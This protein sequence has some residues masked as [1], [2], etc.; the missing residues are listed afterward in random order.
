MNENKIRK[1]VNM[2]VSLFMVCVMCWVISF[3][4][5]SISHSS[6]ISYEYL[7]FDY[8]LRIPSD[9]ILIEGIDKITTRR[10]K[11]KTVV[12]YYKH[13]GSSGSVSTSDLLIIDKYPESTVVE[14]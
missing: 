8:I 10:Y 9:D 6:S 13:D 4:F 2:V 12:E 14:K 5:K 3:A 7:D 11:Y 1:I